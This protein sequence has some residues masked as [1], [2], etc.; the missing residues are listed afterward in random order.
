MF[1]AF[2]LFKNISAV[3]F[4]LTWNA[5]FFMSIATIGTKSIKLIRKEEKAKN[6]LNH[7]FCC[8]QITSTE[9]IEHKNVMLMES[10]SI[11][12]QLQQNPD[13][14]KTNSFLLTG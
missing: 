7:I 8:C 10:F 4:Y 5:C 12:M 2:M 6:V 11:L 9:F 1:H 13:E 14:K 3:I